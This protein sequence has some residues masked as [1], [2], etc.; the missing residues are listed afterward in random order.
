[1]NTL[2]YTW[3]EWHC[4]VEPIQTLVFV[5]CRGVCMDGASVYECELFLDSYLTK[6]GQQVYTLQEII[7]FC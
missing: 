2:L 4:S 3:N 5:A 7:A 6:Q 1:M